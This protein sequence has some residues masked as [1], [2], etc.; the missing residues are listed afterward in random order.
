MEKEIQHL[1][2]S[3][4]GFREEIFGK[5]SN[6]VSHEKKMIR[7][8]KL[9]SNS[10]FQKE[11]NS[12]QYGK[13]IELESWRDQ[14]KNVGSGDLTDEIIDSLIDIQELKT[15]LKEKCKEVKF[16][17][18]KMKIFNE[19]FEKNK[20]NL[21]ELHS[22]IR[23][24]AKEINKYRTFMAE[25]KK[26]GNMLSHNADKEKNAIF[27]EFKDYKDNF[28]SF[29]GDSSVSEKDIDEIRKNWLSNEEKLSVD[30][31]DFEVKMQKIRPEFDPTIENDDIPK[32]DF[33]FIDI[34][35][36]NVS[37]S[38]ICF[39]SVQLDSSESNFTNV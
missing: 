32:N 5:N 36:R 9:N 25:L 3:I 6:E 31:T 27:E 8:Q 7:F 37:S 12:K 14:L 16:L 34:T 11:E 33:K 17:E 26:E 20:T 30:M 13:E 23:M 24:Q 19:L 35:I 1:K 18:D 39:G 29:R 2:E 28:I 21:N 15:R 10:F 22:S 38:D 4:K